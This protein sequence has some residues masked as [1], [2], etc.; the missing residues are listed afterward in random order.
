MFV[1]GEHRCPVGDAKPRER[2]RDPDRTRGGR[3]QFGIPAVGTRDDSQ[4]ATGIF[5]T[6]CRACAASTRASTGTSASASASAGT[7]AFPNTNATGPGTSHSGTA[8]SSAT[9]SRAAHSDAAS[10]G[11]T[12][13]RAAHSNAAS[14]GTT[15]PPRPLRR[16]SHSQAPW[17]PVRG[18]VPPSCTSSKAEQS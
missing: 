5:A 11:T 18:S 17:R 7:D 6:G 12:D 13:S 4:P 14:S 3:A 8:S 2:E 9:D 1:D 10:S 15:D 16:Q